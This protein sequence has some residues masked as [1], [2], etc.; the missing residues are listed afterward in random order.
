MTPTKPTTCIEF[1]P[2]HKACLS[3]FVGQG[4]IFHFGLGWLA[5]TLDPTVTT[6]VSM[7]FVGYQI[8][9]AQTGET[10]SSTGGELLE[11]AL[12]LLMGYV[13]KHR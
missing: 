5:A 2:G 10:W 6:A 4:A 8:S 7:A 13:F 9:Q 11:F 12:G 1:F 3:I